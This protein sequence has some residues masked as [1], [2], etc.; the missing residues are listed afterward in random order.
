MRCA[1][2]EVAE[3]CLDRVRAL[4]ASPPERVA[5]G[6]VVKTLL[7]DVFIVRR[8]LELG[9]ACEDGSGSSEARLVR[10]GVLQGVGSMPAREAAAV[11]LVSSSSSRSPTAFSFEPS[12]FPVEECS[13]SSPCP[14]VCSSKRQ[15]VEELGESESLDEGLEDDCI[16][17]HRERK[18]VRTR[19]VAAFGSWERLRL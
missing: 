14:A 16:I 1:E 2:P 17:M 10:D 13:L 3:R 12:S 6:G 19:F 8:V 9:G 7:A 18:R 5:G 11:P 15:H 4:T